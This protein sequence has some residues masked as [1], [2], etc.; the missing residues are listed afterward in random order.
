[1]TRL[2]FVVIVLLVGLQRLWELRVSRQHEQA[3][4]QE[5]ATEHAPEQMPW[6]RAV[7]TL[8]LVSAIAEV[9]LAKRPFIPALAGC[10]LVVFLAGQTLRLVA[11]RSL[12]PRWTVKIIT[13]P[14]GAPPVS[15]AI[16]RYLRHPN[17]LGVILEIAALPLLHTAYVTAL[18]FSVANG[19][20]LRFRIRA[21]E[22]AL[23]GSSDYAARFQGRARFLPALFRR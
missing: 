17:Y 7:H 1:V 9:Y 14:A 19:I 13:P 18:V 12:G 15:H 3:L 4:L 23:S 21:E 8:W 5:G 22:A 16:Y 10:A 6:M 20:L 2:V 11:M